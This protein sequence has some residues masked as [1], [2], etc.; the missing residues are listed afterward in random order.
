[1]NYDSKPDTLEHIKQVNAYL[2]NFISEL[3]IRARDHDASKLE[4]PEKPAFDKATPKLKALT[5]GSEEYED[6]K[7]LLGQALSHHYEHN[8]HHP[9]FH[10]N[11]VD[12]MTLIDLL[13]MLADWK[14]ATLRHKDGDLYNS[15][16]INS[17]RFKI[18]GQLAQIL[19]N[20]A[21]AE[22]W[23]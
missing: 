4:A 23:L 5:Y 1:M 7:R 6:S 20:T 22:G 10:K 14:A 17:K 21:K 16:H 8:P 13:E 9:E 3:A 11:G 2:L 18:S 15:I 19:L 12:D